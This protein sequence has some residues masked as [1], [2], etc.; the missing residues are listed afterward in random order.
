MA[1]H[2]FAAGQRLPGWEAQADAFAA[3]L[4]PEAA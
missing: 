1:D 2:A 4:T 3:A